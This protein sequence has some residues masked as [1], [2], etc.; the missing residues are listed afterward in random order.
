MACELAFHSGDQVVLPNGAVTLC[1]VYS[2][3]VLYYL[4]A[5]FVSVSG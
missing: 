2:W 4:G 3:V 5:R 1:V